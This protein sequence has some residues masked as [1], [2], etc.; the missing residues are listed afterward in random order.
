MLRA[1]E[2]EAQAEAAQALIG[3][4]MGPDVNSALFTGRETIKVAQ[5]LPNKKPRPV[6][7]GQRLE[8]NEYRSHPLDG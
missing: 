8:I 1:A 2:A 7:A 3:A 4:D 6:F 5:R